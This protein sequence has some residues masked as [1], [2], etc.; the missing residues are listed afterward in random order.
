MV[1]NEITA[2]HIVHISAVLALIAFTFYA[3]AAPPETRKTVLA[4]TGVAFLIV[5][6]TGLR[7]W[8]GLYGF[9]PLGWIIVKLVC[10]V[11]ITGLVGL[12]YRRR[13]Q[14]GLLMAVVLGLAILAVVMVYTKPF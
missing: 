5:L 12:A 13:S 10:A 11:G 3:F 2:L 4:V 14:A 9:A 7:M 6:A 1:P 8:Q